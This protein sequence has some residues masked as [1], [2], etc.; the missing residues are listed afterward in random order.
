MLRRFLQRLKESSEPVFLN[1][2]RVSI[3]RT[4]QLEEALPKVREQLNVSAIPPPDPPLT[5][6]LIASRWVSRDLHNEQIPG[7]AADLLEAGYDTPALIRLA[8]EMHIYASP[9]A[10]RLI[11]KMF[12][13]LGVSW[14]MPE[15]QA[16]LITTRQ[17]AREVMADVR[18]PYQAA[19]H[20]EIVL[21]GWHPP[22]E[23]LGDLFQINDEVSWDSEYRRDPSDIFYD[24]LEAFARIACMTDEQIANVSAEESK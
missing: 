9:D 12:R 10:D 13:E 4:E 17:I 7:I 22:T 8:G 5:P 20:I 14:P 16:K 23:A 1:I 21:W 6:L 11:G 24:R 19:T 3:A 18:D 2:E 15:V